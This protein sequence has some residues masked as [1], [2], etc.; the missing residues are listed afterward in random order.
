[1]I[2]KIFITN[3]LDQIRKYY[4]D[5]EKILNVPIEKLKNDSISGYAIERLFQLIV[6]EIIDINN[7]LIL[8]N[9][10]ETPDDFQ[11]TFSILAKNKIIKENFAERIAPTVGLRNK[12]V[13]RYEK[14]DRD[15]FLN[16]V[17]KEKK[18]LK[19]YVKI[20]GNYLNNL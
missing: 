18:D 13:H 11:S 8:R 9:K 15:L 1:M 17:L 3:K 4:A 5:L 6:D 20:I 16:T 10:L 2:D 12:L 7:H 14:I 19:E